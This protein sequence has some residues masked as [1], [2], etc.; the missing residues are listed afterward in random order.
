MYK[1]YRNICPPEKCTGCMACVST[2]HHEAIHI[3]TTPIGFKYPKIDS[4]KCIN[5]G[6]CISTCPG[7]N[8]PVK[9]FPSNCYAFALRDEEQLHH[10]ASGGVATYLSQQIIK[11]CGV[12]YGCSGEDMTHVRHIRIDST[13][14]IDKLIGSK[15]VQS[16]VIDIATSVLNDL[17]AGTQ[18]LFIGTPCQV[19]GILKFVRRDWDNLITV[20][21]VCHG[22]PSQ[23]LLNDNIAL[24]KAKHPD[25]D[26]N[27]IC[28]RR[29]ANH[30]QSFQIDYGWFY[31]RTNHNHKSNFVKWYYDPYMLGFLS[32]TTLRECCYQC[33]Y[34][35]NIRVSDI[36][37]SDFWG[38][39]DGAGFINGKGVSSI[40]VN[41]EKGIKT[42]DGIVQSSDDY[43]IR[44]RTV[45]ESISGNGHLMCP[46]HKPP[47]IES[48]RKDY[49]ILGWEKS[50]NLSLRKFKFITRLKLIVKRLYNLIFK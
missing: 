13:A 18:V 42:I 22:V 49:P 41:T 9:R 15:Y 23:Q 47:Y 37:I 16:D 1:N 29:K 34:A 17:K 45:Q 26:I 36:T 14:D 44:K 32:R 24:Y 33:E 20:D 4:T 30:N 27:S 5:C 7:N 19:A 8:P 48:F 21:L 10:V 28:F 50:I 40:L 12:V 38:L 6:L 11:R 43:I 31:K 35:Y 3:S 39:S 2:C 46:G 25:I